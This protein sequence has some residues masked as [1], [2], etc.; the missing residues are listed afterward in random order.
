MR[1]KDQLISATGN[2]AHRS[3]A[4]TRKGKYER[5]VATTPSIYQHEAADTV[6]KI[7]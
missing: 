7:F 1:S 4:K 5:I 2:T 3:S 6:V